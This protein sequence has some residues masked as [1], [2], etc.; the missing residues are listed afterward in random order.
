MARFPAKFTGTPITLLARAVL[1]AVMIWTE[2]P[3][4]D[5]LSKVRV[6]PLV[7]RIVNAVEALLKTIEP[8]V[9]LISRV[10][11]SAVS[12]TGSPLAR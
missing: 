9:A 8:T 10:T 12:K 6:D 7:V 3:L 11:V 1:G 2:L 5:P 4:P